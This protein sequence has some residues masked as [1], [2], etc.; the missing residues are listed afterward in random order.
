MLPTNTLS[1]NY[2]GAVYLVN[3][4]GGKILGRKAYRN[5]TEIEGNIDLVVVTIPA[6]KVIDLIPALVEKR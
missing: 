3:P 1:R 2:K 5:L 6:E 4:K